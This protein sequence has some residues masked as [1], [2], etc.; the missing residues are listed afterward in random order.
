MSRSLPERSIADMADQLVPNCSHGGRVLAP[1]DRQSTAE[2]GTMR[3]KLPISGDV[4]HCNCLLRGLYTRN[5]DCD[6]RASY[7]L[8]P[9]YSTLYTLWSTS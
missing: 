1:S 7:S 4:E 2:V 3:T 6:D 9:T 5:G 8:T